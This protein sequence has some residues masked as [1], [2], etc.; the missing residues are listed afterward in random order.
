MHGQ[1]VKPPN[2]PEPSENLPLR[3]ALRSAWAKNFN[4]QFLS[5][6]DDT[7]LEYGNDIDKREGNFLDKMRELVSFRA[8]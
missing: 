4:K 8:R 6:D 3:Y 2:A 1:F 5:E 7:P